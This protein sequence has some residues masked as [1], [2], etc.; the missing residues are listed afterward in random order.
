MAKKSARREPDP[1]LE[2][3]ELELESEEAPRKK[4]GSAKL[5]KSSTGKRKSA[6]PEGKDRNGSSSISKKASLKDSGKRKTA[7]GRAKRP[8]S[9]DDDDDGEVTSSS[10]RRKRAVPAKKKDNTVVL[11]SVITMTVLLVIGVI[12]INKGRAPK[13]QR[14][15]QVEYGD[16]KKLWTE[17]E[18][19]FRA[20]N[21]AEK[22]GDAAVAKQKHDEAHR[23]L[24]AALDALEKILADKRGPDGMLPTEYEGYEEDQSKISTLLYDLGKRGTLR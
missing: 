21:T 4:G 24:T 5:G 2:D 16:F 3:E 11:I 12:V 15:E 6:E 17:G 8:P 1:D 14:N 23:K 9:E 22:A 19:A 10:A 13:P 20:F 18:T 7:T